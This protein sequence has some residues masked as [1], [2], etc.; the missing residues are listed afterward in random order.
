MTDC[1]MDIAGYWRERAV[2]LF[3]CCAVTGLFF[4]HPARGGQAPHSSHQPS[5][6]A[7]LQPVIRRTAP[8]P[9]QLCV[10]VRNVRGETVDNLRQSD[11]R[12]W[13][14]N[15]LQRISDFAGNV[16]P[17]PVQNL[18]TPGTVRY[19]ALYFDDL[20]YD[21]TDTI[22]VTDSAYLY[23]KS[24]LEPGNKVGVFTSSGEVTLNFTDDKAKLHQTLLAIKPHIP[25]ASQATTC[26]QLSDFQALML[27]YGGDPLPLRIALD[28]MN[29]CS[30][31]SGQEDPPTSS[32]PVA[33]LRRMTESINLRAKQVI[34]ESE[35]QSRKTLDGL[36]RLITQVS[37]LPDPRSIIVASPGFLA[38]SQARQ[39]DLLA[40]RAT[41]LHI[42]ISTLDIT[43]LIRQLSMP[44]PTQNRKLDEER[45]AIV[46]AKNQMIADR[47]SMA[48]DVLLDLSTMTGGNFIGNKDDL[49][50]G[51]R[52][53]IP[54]PPAYYVLGYT[55][56]DSSE[57]G[58]FHNVRIQVVRHGLM[59]VQAPSGYYAP[60]T[61]QEIARSSVRDR[62]SSGRRK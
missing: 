19:T 38:G 12:L 21:F 55:P 1:G 20:H 15:R 29:A 60:G 48:A 10:V 62:H 11:F 31:A 26:P 42:I 34:A 8:P 49:E 50:S 25:S 6:T 33:T 23:F 58:R 17:E 13:D 51:F 44:A 30:T 53:A 3:L 9:V 18:K 27:L 32:L 35:A 36:D 37:A 47:A 16:I 24:T 22:R 41:R 40:R 59:G 5:P 52:A 46:A 4:T 61:A 54:L 45:E 57:N 39:V 56:T 43:G 14:N 7:R 2:R 28:D